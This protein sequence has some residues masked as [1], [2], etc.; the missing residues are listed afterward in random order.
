MKK[1]HLESTL[2]AYAPQ[3]HKRISPHDGVKQTALRL[4]SQCEKLFAIA[5]LIKPIFVHP[6]I[7]ELTT[8]E[9]GQVVN[10][11]GIDV[12]YMQRIG[13][14]IVNDIASYRGK[15]AT[16]YVKATS[17]PIGYT[18]GDELAHEISIAEEYRQ[19]MEDYVTVVCQSARNLENH[20][21]AHVPV[22]HRVNFGIDA[23]ESIVNEQH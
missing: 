17:E 3:H 18:C 4:N 12:V 15:L 22:E 5:Q 20:F 16:I 7:R 19:W 9:Q 23:I 21:N 6:L 13:Q 11:Y 14:G 2:N 1:T 10:K 8:N